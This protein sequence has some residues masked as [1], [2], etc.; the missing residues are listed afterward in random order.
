MQGMVQAE[1]IAERVRRRERHGTGADNRGVQQH[2]G[3]ERPEQTPAVLIEPPCDRPRIR[4]LA[5]QG[6][7][8]KG[9]CGRH[10]QGRRADD[11]HQGA[12]RGV[13]PLIPH[14]AGRNALVDHIRLLKGT[15]KLAEQ[16]RKIGRLKR[17]RVH[18]DACR[19]VAVQR[20]PLPGRDH[21]PLRVALLSLPSQLEFGVRPLTV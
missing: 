10:H 19:A 1:D 17:G 20:T 3:K 15:V 12:D 6:R 16:C 4:E 21:Q 5:G 9:V 7:P 11:H 18:G 14:P 8:P 13:D 2:D